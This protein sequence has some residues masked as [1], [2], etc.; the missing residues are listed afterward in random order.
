VS[1]TRSEEREAR[2]VS[3]SRWWCTILST[4]VALGCGLSPID[5][6]IKL[7]EEPFVVLVGE[8]NDRNTD[9]FTTTTSSGHVYQLTFTRVIE[10]APAL[11]NG[12]GMVAFLRLRDTLPGTRRDVVV[13]ILENGAEKTIPLPA[14]AG[15]A[16]ALG[17]RAGDSVVYIRTD[18]GLWQANIPVSGS[19][20]T[21]VSSADSIVA[22]QVTGAWLGQPPFA[23]AI[24][25]PAGICII[26]PR[27]DTTTLSAT[28]H[29]PMRWG[30]DSVAWFE[31]SEIVVRSLGAGRARR[32][33]LKDAPANLRQGSMGGAN[34]DW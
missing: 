34:G 1:S 23:Q 19:E 14:T 4:S 30:R 5:H 29:D 2:S 32:V 7:G 12:G 26:G 25:C 33:M 11:A 10:Q 20:A 15:L 28:G 27:H 8:G 24:Q 16:L 17:W 9:L 22:S 6:R 3:T 18:R 13:M 31:G 21:A